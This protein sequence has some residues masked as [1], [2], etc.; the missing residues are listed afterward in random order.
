M[1]P[2]RAIGGRHL[3]SGIRGGLWEKKHSDAMGESVFLFG[4]LV[5]RQTTQR[6][7][8]G[9][10]LRGKPLTYA[11]ITTDTG[12][13][14]RTLQRWMARLQEAGYIEVSHS[15]YSR[16]VIRILNAKKFNPKQLDLPTLSSQSSTPEVADL[17]MPTQADSS[18]PLLADITTKSGGLKEGTEFEQKHLG[19]GVAA[20]ATASDTLNPWK[21][22]GSDLPMGSPKFQAIFQHYFATRNGNP[23]SDAMERAI[24]KA[25]K[26]KVKVPPQFFEAKRSVE[27]REAEELASYA[28]SE[29][30]ELEDLPWVNR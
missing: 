17:S 6:N 21:V 16:M 4:W 1:T 9:L 28:D 14:E 30:P 19:S 29:R 12:W 15:I 20:A 24:Q 5:L 26:E 7:G 8:T 18:T 3:N 23:L 25:N 27:R 2:R 11:D 13:P 22:L 10:V